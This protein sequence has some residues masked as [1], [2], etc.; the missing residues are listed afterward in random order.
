MFQDRKYVIFNVS[1]LPQIN[2]NEVLETSMETVRKSLDETQTFVKWEGGDVPTC[3][4]NLT[5]KSQYYTHSEIIEILSSLE[6]S[7]PIDEEMIVE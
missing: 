3:V 1:E 7:N 2:F 5:T 6:W 4:E